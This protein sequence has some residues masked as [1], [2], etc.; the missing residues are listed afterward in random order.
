VR[1]WRAKR[2]RGKRFFG[3]WVDFSFHG[4]YLLV[5]HGSEESPQSVPAN[6]LEADF[7]PA[8]KSAIQYRI[9]SALTPAEAAVAIA[10]S[11]SVNTSG[12]VI[13]NPANFHEAR[14]WPGSHEAN[15]N[16]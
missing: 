16:P 2:F 15:R 4:D 8:S 12:L 6:F 5:A 9:R 14:L 1:K 10:A 13:T 7:R 11:P 3:L